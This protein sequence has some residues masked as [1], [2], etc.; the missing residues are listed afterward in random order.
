MTAFTVPAHQMTPQD[1]HL[2]LVGAIVRA[3]QRPGRMANGAI[4]S[5]VFKTWKNVRP[6]RI[7]FPSAGAATAASPEMKKMG[8]LEWGPADS[9]MLQA[10]STDPTNNR[11][12]I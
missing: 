11:R 4:F 7:L 6:K 5:P 2:V 12:S 9:S 3:C 10:V 8:I 1:E